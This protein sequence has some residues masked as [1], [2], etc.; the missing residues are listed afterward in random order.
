MDI[1]KF[2]IIFFFDF[3]LQIFL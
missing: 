2:P 1:I 3:F